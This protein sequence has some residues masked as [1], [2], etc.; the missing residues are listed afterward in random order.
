MPRRK[1]SIRKRDG[2]WR[3]TIPGYGFAADETHPVDSQTAG[4]ELLLN[5]SYPRTIGAGSSPRDQYAPSRADGLSPI[6]RWDPYWHRY[7]RK[8]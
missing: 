1:P 2:E 6:P 5:R 7:N 3:I 8:F 4:V